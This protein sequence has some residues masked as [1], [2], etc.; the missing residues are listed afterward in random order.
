[1]YLQVVFKPISHLFQDENNV[2]RI[3]MSVGLKRKRETRLKCENFKVDLCFTD[4]VE[5]NK[6]TRY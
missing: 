1:M 3:G 6:R 4:D 2:S 5:K